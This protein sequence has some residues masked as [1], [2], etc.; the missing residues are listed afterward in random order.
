MTRFPCSILTPEEEF[1]LF[2]RRDTD[3]RLLNSA[4]DALLLAHIP[5]VVQI[6]S[7]HSIPGCTTEDLVGEGVIGLRK[8][9]HKFDPGA[10]AR[11]SSYARWWIVKR[12][13]Y[14]VSQK[15]AAVRI[16]A[17]A[18]RQKRAVFRAT[19]SLDAPDTDNLNKVAQSAQL[20]RRQAKTS[21]RTD[22]AIVPPDSEAFQLCAAE[23]HSPDWQSA[24]NLDGNLVTCAIEEPSE[25]MEAALSQQFEGIPS[26]ETPLQLLLSRSEIR[27]LQKIAI[28]TLALMLDPTKDGGPGS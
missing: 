27:R 22:N 25:E 20:S 21:L 10:G 17:W 18:Q 7:R 4:V 11:L 1:V 13:R 5:L 9:I 19:N 14:A 24:M 3:G 8:A 12:V 6:A 2:L 16:P 26:L 28:K 15:S 23:E